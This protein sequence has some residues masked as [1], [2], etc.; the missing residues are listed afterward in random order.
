MTTGL[1]TTWTA[2]LSI[3]LSFLPAWISSAVTMGVVLIAACAMPTRFASTT[4][5]YA[6]PSVTGNS[7]AAMAEARGACFTQLFEYYLANYEA[8]HNNAACTRDG[9]VPSAGRW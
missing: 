8:D 4:N 7:A 1:L 2:H 9:I 6:S 3:P 5:A